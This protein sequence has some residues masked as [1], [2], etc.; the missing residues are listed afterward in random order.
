MAGNL[1]SRCFSAHSYTAQTPAF[2]R[3][4]LRTSRRA[5]RMV[6]RATHTPSILVLPGPH[7]T[8]TCVTMRSCG[9]SGAGVMPCAEV[10]IVKAKP[11]IA[12]NLSIVSS[13]VL[14][15]RPGWFFSRLGCCLAD[16]RVVLFRLA[17]LD[18]DQAGRRIDDRAIRAVID[19]RL[20][21]GHGLN[22]NHLPFRTMAIGAIVSRRVPVVGFRE[23]LAQAG[24]VNDR[25]LGV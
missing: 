8:A 3:A 16:M 7:P 4:H 5:W 23:Q 22:Q 2:H 15:G 9:A 10:A 25:T 21:N 19:V 1:K 12:I 11:P 20:T 6:V 24:G 18:T 13:C 14:C 17:R